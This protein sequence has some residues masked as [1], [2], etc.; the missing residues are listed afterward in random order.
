MYRRRGSSTISN[1]QFPLHGLFRTELCFDIL[2][3]RWAWFLS[4]C[5]FTT[6]DGSAASASGRAVKHSAV[7]ASAISLLSF[8]CLWGF[9]ICWMGLMG[10]CLIYLLLIR[11]NHGRDDGGKQS[12][13]PYAINARHV[14]FNRPVPS[15]STFKASQGNQIAL[16][17]PLIHP[18][19]N[20]N[21]PVFLRR[22]TS[23]YSP[24]T[25]L[26]RHRSK[27]S[28]SPKRLSSSPVFPY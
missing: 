19:H 1:S 27:S 11:C 10:V 13:I 25:M 9:T 28:E 3:D 16:H 23:P 22:H 24:H 18:S 17:A 6:I 4:Q 14:P 5:S 8:A 12:Q 21:L 7:P 15:C 26:P 2:M 20:R